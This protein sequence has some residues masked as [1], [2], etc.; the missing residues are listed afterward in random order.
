[1]ATMTAATGLPWG[2]PL[3]RDDLDRMPDD[4]HRYEL[5]DGS[6]LVSPAPRLSHQRAAFRLARLLDDA[7]PSDLEVVVAP[8][9]V[10]LG[11][12]TVLLPDLLV[13][14][15][16][17]FTE[18]ELSG[19]P[20]LAVEVL[21]PSTRRIDITVK[22]DRFRAAGTPSYWVVDPGEPSLTAWELA[23]DGGYEEVAR[24][25]GGDGARLSRP[26]AV[27]VVPSDLVDDRG[28]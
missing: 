25:T 6:L 12:D 7:C 11:A 27:D 28:G 3:V 4:G 16:S 19:A 9:D 8:F 21:S 10:V 13:A 22:R 15:R 14:R 20:V 23:P 2:R 17:D 18:R 26:Y 5:L 24:V 1:M